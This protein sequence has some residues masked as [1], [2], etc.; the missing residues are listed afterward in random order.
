MT[1]PLIDCP[2]RV[3]RLQRNLYR[4]IALAAWLVYAYLW[5]PLLTFLAWLLGIRTAYERLYIDEHAIDPFIIA[6]LPVIAL[7]C[8]IVLIGWAEYNRFRFSD[9]DRRRR[10][11]DVDETAVDNRLGADHVLGD[12]LRQHRVIRVMLDEAAIPVQ[13]EVL[14]SR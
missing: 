10:R 11:R 1:P 6:A 13:V 9:A 12:C 14:R 5:V 8:A 7:I 4:A 3:T 2:D